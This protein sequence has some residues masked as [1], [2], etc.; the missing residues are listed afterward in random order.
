M[1]NHNVTY[2]VR[3][4]AHCGQSHISSVGVG[5]PPKFHT[6]AEIVDFIVR[7]DSVSA[8]GTLVK[9][10]TC[11]GCQQETVAGLE[12]TPDY[13]PPAGAGLGDQP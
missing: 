13:H 2:V 1:A 3:F 6:V 12:T 5:E 10:S 11:P 9:R 7:G 4:E 8:D